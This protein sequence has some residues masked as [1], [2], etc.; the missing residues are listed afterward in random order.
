MR[1]IGFFVITMGLA[2]TS[3][4]VATPDQNDAPRGGSSTNSQGSAPASGD[5]A[6]SQYVRSDCDVRRPSCRRWRALA[7]DRLEKGKGGD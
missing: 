1:R 6:R 4:A 3:P 7:G 2:W 5:S